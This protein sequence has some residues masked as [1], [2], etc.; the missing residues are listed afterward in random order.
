MIRKKYIYSMHFFSNIFALQM[1]GSRHMRSRG[2]IV[3]QRD[4]RYP[5]LIQLYKHMFLKY[6]SSSL[7]LTAQ[8]KSFE[9]QL[10]SPVAYN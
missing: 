7:S 8:G 3:I 5:A 10:S 6:G 1:V 4:P 9:M 2:L